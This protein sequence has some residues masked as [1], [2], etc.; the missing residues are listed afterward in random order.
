MDMQKGVLFIYTSKFVTLK[1][2]NFMS[3]LISFK[4]NDR[5][6]CCYVARPIYTSAAYQ[7][8]DYNQSA[9]IIRTSISGLH[10]N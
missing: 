8:L 7:C 1:G 6:L 2:H 9:F 5:K 10:I 3:K 4:Y